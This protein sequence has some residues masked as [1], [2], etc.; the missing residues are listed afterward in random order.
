MSQ[1]FSKWLKLEKELQAESPRGAEHRPA[2]QSWVMVWITGL[3]VEPFPSC[4]PFPLAQ[5]MKA[6]R[7]EIHRA[8]VCL[9][10]LSGCPQNTIPSGH[11]P[12]GKCRVFS[13]DGENFLSAY[14]TGTLSQRVELSTWKL[15]DFE[16]RKKTQDT[17]RL[18]GGG[19][20]FETL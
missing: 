5:K 3:A 10:L 20:F 18:L 4:P 7:V 9:W 11:G 6:P 8:G 19:I 12:C 16:Q 14:E 13:E 2:G 17:R 1:L 15:M